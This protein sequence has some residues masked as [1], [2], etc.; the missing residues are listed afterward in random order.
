MCF[1]ATGGRELN[2]RLCCVAKTRGSGQERVFCTSYC[3]NTKHS[4]IGELENKLASLTQGFFCIGKCGDEVQVSQLYSLFLT[5][6]QLPPH[7][8]S[9]L[10]R[11]YLCVGTALCFFSPGGF[12][13]DL[14]FLFSRE[15][16]HYGGTRRLLA[17]N[18]SSITK[19]KRPGLPP[20]DPGGFLRSTDSCIGTIADTKKLQQLAF[21]ISLSWGGGGSLGSVT[22]W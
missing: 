9:S 7:P 19:G 13:C 12:S 14:L 22:T 15:P 18:R 20:G 3:A 11:F 2:G 5:F 21:S 4:L 17:G 1:D 8:P 16:R 10:R 6:F